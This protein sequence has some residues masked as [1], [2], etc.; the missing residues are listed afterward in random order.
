MIAIT[1]VNNKLDH[2][3]LAISPVGNYIT[4]FLVCLLLVSRVHSG[5]SRSREG[6][7]CVEQM[8]RNAR[9]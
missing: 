4:G 7:I 6:Q 2:L 3:D 8:N 9:E 5:V 1:E